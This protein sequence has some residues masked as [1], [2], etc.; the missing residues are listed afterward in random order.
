MPT[1]NVGT[2][3]ISD[4]EQELEAM[5]HGTTLNQITNLQEAENRAARRVLGDVDPQETKIVSQFGKLYD[6]V[7]DYPLAE[8]VKGNK[9]IDLFPQANRNL[10]DNFTQVYNK[11]FDIGKGFTLVPDFTPRYAGGVRTVRINATNL[12]TGILINNADGYNTNGTW[13]AGTNVSNVATNNQ[14]FTDGASGSVSFQLNQTGIPGSVGIISNAT[15]AAVD[16]TNHYNNAQEFF[17][18]YVPNASG[19]TS[20]RYRFGSS[21]ANYYDSGDITTTQMGDTFGDGWNLV[22]KGW[23]DFSIVGSPNVASINY[24]RIAITYD[25]TLQTQVL[26]NQFWSRLGVIFNQEYYSKYLFRDAIT[27]EFQEKVTDPTNYVNLDTDAV[28]LFLFA[29]LGEVVQQQQGADALYFDANQAEQRYTSELASYKGKYRG[30]TQKP[31]TSYYR[32]PQAGYRRFFGW[33]R[34]AR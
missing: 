24:I 4:I 19:I 12:Q 22:S 5:L 27:G 17:Q 2:Y 23:A 6:G 15:M 8:D 11:D 10:R 7:W 13:T 25:G 31:H 28:N 29:L 21:A 14:Y 34:G 26:L 20:I 1:P 33:N 30:E 16:L 32:L 3:Q 18:F 9:I